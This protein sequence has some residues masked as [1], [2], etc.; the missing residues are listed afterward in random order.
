VKIMFL[1]DTHGDRGFTLSA[2]RWCAANGID[3]IVQYGDFGYWPRTNNGQRFLHDVGKASVQA[4]VPLFW[5]DGN[6]EDHLHLKALR[7]RNEGPMI[8]IGKYPVTYLDRGGRF[9]WDGCTFGA[10]GGAFSIDRPWRV[11]DSGQYGWFKEEV[12]DETKIEALG[13]VDV[14]ISHDAPIIPP[15]MYGAGFKDDPTSRQ[16]Q[17]AVYEALVSTGA[18]FVIHGHWHLRETYGVHGATVQALA[19]NQD[20]LYDAAVIFDT[21]TRELITLRKVE[22]GNA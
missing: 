17:K 16:C 9:E 10:F 20:S 11:E 7:E 18:K 8:H 4:H 19:M 14:L 6:H 3:R 12:P 1:G 5:I 2:I 15:M 13:K 22:Y 21:Q